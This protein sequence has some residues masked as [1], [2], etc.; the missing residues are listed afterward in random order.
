MDTPLVSLIVPVYNVAAYLPECLA[1][2][3][4]QTFSDFECILVNDGSTDESGA[5]CRAAADADER[6][7]L[8]EQENAGVAAARNRALDAARGKYLQFADSDDILTPDAA[9]VFVHTAESTGCDLA[10]SHFYRLAGKRAVER[11]HIRTACVMTR[12][13]YA[14][15]MM[16]A[17]ANYYYGVLWNKL[18]RRSLVEAGRLRFRDGVDWCEDFLFNLDYIAQVR[19]ATAIPEPLYYYRKREDSLVSTRTTLRRV[20]E[21]KRSTFAAYKELYRQLDLYEEQKAQIY[22]YLLSSATDGL[23]VPFPPPSK[24]PKERSSRKNVPTKGA[25]RTEKSKS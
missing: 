21:T 13:E 23:T 3:R 9:A 22:G 8:L 24:A 10:V 6:F 25:A 17:P 7:V 11:G 16:K 18:Y 4:A 5:I 14:E 20:I 2:I 15:H 1:S 12:R 19:L